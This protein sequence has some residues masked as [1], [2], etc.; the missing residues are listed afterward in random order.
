MR[1]AWIISTYSTLSGFAGLAENAMKKNPNPF[2][3]LL[4]ISFMAACASAVV[5][6]IVDKWIRTVP[7]GAYV[8]AA[9]AVML[10]GR[11]IL[12]MNGPHSMYSRCRAAFGASLLAVM[13]M[14]LT[15]QPLPAYGAAFSY[16]AS[17]LFALY[18]GIL[19]TF[20][21]AGDALPLFIALVSCVGGETV[22]CAVNGYFQGLP[23]VQ[24]P[25]W[26]QL[27]SSRAGILLPPLA[28]MACA[29]IAPF[30]ISALKH[31]TSAWSPSPALQKVSPS[32]RLAEDATERPAIHE[33]QLPFHSGKTSLLMVRQDVDETYTEKSDIDDILSSVVYFMSRN[34]KAYSALGFIY[35]PAGGAFTLNSF[36]SKSFSIIK[37]IRIPLG[38]GVVGKVGIDKQTFISGDLTHYSAEVL[39]YSGVSP[40]KSIVATPV[41]SDGKE[42]LGALVIDSQDP[43]AFRDEHKEIL[44]RFSSLAAALITNVRMRLYQERAANQFQIFY[45]ASQQFINALRIEQVFAVLV[46]M[47]QQITTYT[48]I[49]VITGHEKDGTGVVVKIRG[50]S[51]EINEGFCF[52]FNSGLYSY[53]LQKQKIV[54]VAD[55]QE[56]KGKYFRFTPEESGSDGIRSLIII[57]IMGEDSRPIGLLSIE[58]NAPNQFIGEMETILFTLVGNA[59]VAITRARLYQQMELLAITDG[60]TQLMNHKHFQTQLGKEIERS[61]RYKRSMSLLILDIDHFKSFNDTYGHPVGDLVLREIA[62]CIKEAIRANDQAARYGGEEFAVIIPETDEQG[63]LVTAERIRTNIEAKIIQSGNDRLRVTISVGCAAYPAHA[64]NQKDLIENADKALYY[65][66]ENGRNRSSLFTKAMTAHG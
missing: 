65:S 12:T 41:I 34:F 57:P 21:V 38:R 32:R 55:F 36:H 26:M 28:Y 1:H 4:E 54:N 18:Y 33:G 62:Q 42:L 37:N 11:V 6:G 24:N 35:D 29:G 16:P 13:A 56:F 31:R 2:L 58:S 64:A 60:L 52:T 22:N 53:A 8:P 61:R 63:A 7:Y 45:E 44:R 14:H 5:S 43:Q 10:L 46:S 47:A 66:K 15:M 39:Y 3:M 40:V 59:S 17:P 48:R 20:G 23:D 27:V 25:Q 49:M 50:A 9:I 30:F 51:P 19:I